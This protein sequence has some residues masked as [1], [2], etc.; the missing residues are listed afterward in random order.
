[1][2]SIA[3]LVTLTS[4]LLPGLARALYIQPY[5]AAG[6]QQLQTAGKP[7][8]V[9]FHADWCSTCKAQERAFREI[10]D[11]PELKDVALLV[12]HYDDERD[13]KRAMNVRSQSVIVV[14]KGAKETARLGG[15]TQPAKI[16]AAL[17][18]AR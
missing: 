15:E 9:H 16:K 2:K 5:T 7:A 13:L 1:M 4:L 11:D 10:K 18:T 8:A 6:L 3:I 14:F 17:L 12:A